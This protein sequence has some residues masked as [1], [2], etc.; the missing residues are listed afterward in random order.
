MDLGEVLV[1]ASV[2]LVLT[3]LAVL[4]QQAKDAGRARGCAQACKDE[5]KFPY[6]Q[7]QVCFC[8]EQPVLKEGR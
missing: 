6:L 2:V 5:G 7:A 3:A 1:V 8:V 4:G